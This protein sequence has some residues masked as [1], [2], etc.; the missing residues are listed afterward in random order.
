MYRQG[1]PAA[2]IAAGAGVAGSVVRYHLT[3]AGKEDPGLRDE[4]RKALLCP[5][6]LTMAGRR[7]LNDL[8]AFWDAEKRLPVTGRDARESKLP[9]VRPGSARRPPQGPS[10]PLTPVPSTR[11]PAGGT[12]PRSATPMRPA[13]R[14]A[15]MKSPL[16]WLPAVTGPCTT[17]P[18]TGRNAPWESGSTPSA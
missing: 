15:S 17:G 5:A 18:M 7:T 10:H 3:L 4:H 8:L 14:S 13:G 6:R 12:N 16:T 1:I 9:G 11:F 2:K